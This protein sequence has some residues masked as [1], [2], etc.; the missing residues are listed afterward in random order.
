MRSLLS[1]LNR[2]IT[3]ASQKVA[4]VV[5]TQTDGKTL[6]DFIASKEYKTKLVSR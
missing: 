6:A 3:R 2:E 5:S 1:T 4:I